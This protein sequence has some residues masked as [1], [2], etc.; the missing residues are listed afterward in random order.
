MAT[1]DN[2]LL[3][4]D[5]QS[6]D[7][8]NNGKYSNLNLNQKHHCSDV[9]L[10]TPKSATS[11]NRKLQYYG[12]DKFGKAKSS[13]AISSTLSLHIAAYENLN[14]ARNET[15]NDCDEKKILKKED[16]KPTLNKIWKNAK[17]LFT[18]SP[19]L[20]Q[21]SFE[22][23]RQSKNRNI[24]PEIAQFKASQKLFIPNMIPVMTISKVS[25]IDKQAKKG[26]NLW[27][28]SD[29]HL[30]SNFLD[31]V[32]CNFSEGKDKFART[33]NSNANSSTLS[34]HIA[35]YENLDEVKKETFNDCDEKKILKKEDEKPTLNKIWKNAKQLFTGS[36]SL[37]QNSFEFPRQ[38]KNQ[39]IN[40]EIAQF[41][42]SQKCLNPNMIPAMSKSFFLNFPL[43]RTLQ[44]PDWTEFWTGRGI[45]ELDW[46]FTNWTSNSWT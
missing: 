14:E 1:R 46:E 39:N 4:K 29:K 6:R 11:D 2:C 9:L 36:P 25:D 34:L 42:A 38:S 16:E 19:S 24:K 32:D 10:V 27:N 35:A 3:F 18:G 8:D 23:P 44:T 37:T 26:Q 43:A 40:P 21:N 12:K 31:I 41:K 45:P 15:Y 22:F 30:S 5:K 33:K 7:I 28:K 20:T 17:Q 13:S